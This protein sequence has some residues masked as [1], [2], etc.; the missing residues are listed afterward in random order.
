MTFNV[1]SNDMLFYA[2][3]SHADNS[4]PTRHQVDLSGRS[5]SCS[6]NAQ[7]SPEGLHVCTRGRWINASA[8]S[9]LKETLLRFLTVS[10]KVPGGLS[11]SCP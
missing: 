6:V 4:C 7:G 3:R 11:L 5:R 2:Q 9:P 8:S 10:H 1:K